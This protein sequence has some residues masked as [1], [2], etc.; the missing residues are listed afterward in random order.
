MKDVNDNAEIKQDTGRPT[1][2]GRAADLIK[3]ALCDP[4]APSCNHPEVATYYIIH[5]VKY[6]PSQIA[7]GHENWYGYNSDWDLPNGVDLC[8]YLEDPRVKH[9]SKDDGR[10]FGSSQAALVYVHR[11]VPAV[12]PTEIQ[13]AV[14]AQWSS[15]D[16]ETPEA[17]Q[18]PEILQKSRN[19]LKEA[20]K[21]GDRNKNTDKGLSLVRAEIEKEQ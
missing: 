11:N 1:D 20:E 2:L 15:A 8:T 12:T 5:V 17:E 18:R 9:H 16:L 7:V 6:K 3:L 13:Q 4:N 14:Q 21:P 10:I 19:L